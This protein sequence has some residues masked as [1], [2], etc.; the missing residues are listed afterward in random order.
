MPSDNS[1]NPGRGRD[2]EA[3]ALKALSVHFQIPFTSNHAIEIGSPAKFHRFD[4]VG[5]RGDQA[6][7]AGECKCYSWTETGNVPSAKMAFI[8]EA[9]LYLSCLPPDVLRF[10]VLP[11]ARHAKRQETLAEYYYRTY[12]HL[13][14]GVSVLEIDVATGAIRTFGQAHEGATQ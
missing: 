11:L 10:V 12:R 3:V 6:V 14:R 13:L 2:F 8:N 7:I 9:L 4:L 1:L 5:L